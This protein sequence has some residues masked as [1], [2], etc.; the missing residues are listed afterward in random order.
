MLHIYAAV[1]EKERRLISERTRAGLARLKALGV[2][3]GNPNA[4][5]AAVLARASLQAKADRDAER[6]WD[7]LAGIVARGIATDRG[8]A[9]G[10]EQA[11][12]SV[13]ARRRGQ[14]VRRQRRQSAAAACSPRV[15]VSWGTGHCTFA[16]A[17]YKP[18]AP[19]LAGEARDQADTRL[20]SR[21]RRPR[22]R[23]RSSSRR[24][25]T[26]RP[27]PTLTKL[28]SARTLVTRHGLHVLKRTAGL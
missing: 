5:A 11:R 26:A 19:K 21:L 27:W 12:D 8:I 7:H 18:G 14:V 1:A 28:R 15:K 3:L 24:A 4:P 23:R 20:C 13:S 17:A 2:K 25:A 16:A 6:I 10:T 22:F 9:D